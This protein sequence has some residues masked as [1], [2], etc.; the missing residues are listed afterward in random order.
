MV[1]QPGPWLDDPSYDCRSHSHDLLRS[2]RKQQLCFY[3]T[4]T[5]WSGKLG[6]AFNTTAGA[7]GFR[8]FPHL[9]GDEGESQ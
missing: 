4:E 5:R 2:N 6:H 8:D 9:V 1:I 3:K 7:S